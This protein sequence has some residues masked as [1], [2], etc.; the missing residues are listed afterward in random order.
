MLLASL[1]LL[2]VTVAGLL[3]ALAWLGMTSARSAVRDAE[4]SAR[5]YHAWSHDRAVFSQSRDS[6]AEAAQTASDAVGQVGSA[7]RLVTRRVLRRR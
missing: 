4:A 5:R 2:A 7:V 3:L 1:A 6:V